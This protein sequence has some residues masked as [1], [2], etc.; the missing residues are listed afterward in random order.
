MG[1]SS[2]IRPPLPRCAQFGKQQVGQC[3]MGLGVCYSCGYSGYIIRDCPTRGD[4]SI[5]QPARSVAG[6]S[7]SIKDSLIPI[8][9]GAC[10]GMERDGTCGSLAYFAQG[11]TER[12]VLSL[13][14]SFGVK[15]L[16]DGLT[17]APILMLTEGTDGNVIYCDASGIGLDWIGLCIDAACIQM[18][19]YVALYRWKC[20]PSIGRFDV[21]ETMLVG[22]ELVQQA[23]KKIKI[24]HERLLAAQSCQKS[25]ADNRRRD[26]EFQ[27]S[28]L[29]KCIEDPSIIVS[30]DN[31]QFT[32]HLSYEETPISILDRQVRRLRTKDVASVKVL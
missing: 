12:E 28:M 7:L 23:I 30:V 9:R 27:V 3:R 29:H 15:A 22:P 6:S 16:K 17:S 1:E 31:V 24:I 18:A 11:S 13:D 8:S 2:Q 19:P 4:A 5:A 10:F 14:I 26:L 21:G 32:E 25:Y 20:R